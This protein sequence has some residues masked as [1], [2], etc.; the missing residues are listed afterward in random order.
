MT[1]DSPLEN[2]RQN[3]IKSTRKT[4]HIIDLEQTIFMLRRAMTFI[5]KLCKKRGYILFVPHH[6]KQEQHLYQ[7]SQKKVQIRQRVENQQEKSQEKNLEQKGAERFIA[8]RDKTEDFVALTAQDLENKEEFRGQA[9][10]EDS[11]GNVP[12]VPPTKDGDAAP[13]VGTRT[14]KSKDQRGFGTKKLPC[15]T[16]SESPL[17][18]FYQDFVNDDKPIYM[19]MYQRRKGRGLFE[20]SRTKYDS[21]SN[22]ETNAK[23]A[24]IAI[25]KYESLSHKL[26]KTLVQRPEGEKKTINGRSPS[27][28]TTKPSSTR[29]ISNAISLRKNNFQSRWPNT[30]NMPR[31]SPFRGVPAEMYQQ[32][33][34]LKK[35]LLV[36]LDSIFYRNASQ[37]N[38]RNT[39]APCQENAN[40]NANATSTFGLQTLNLKTSS[41]TSSSTSS[42]RLI[43][44]TNQ[45]LVPELLQET[46]LDSI[47]NKH[48]E[49]ETPQAQNLTKSSFPTIRRRKP[50]QEQ[51]HTASLFECGSP[52]D[53]ATAT[54]PILRQ[55]ESSQKREGDK[56]MNALPSAG[57]TTIR[58]LILEI[59]K[60]RSQRF[61]IPEALFLFDTIENH[62][63]IREAIKLQ[64][65]IIAIIDSN[66][67]TFGID[68]PIPGNTQSLDSLDLYTQFL[69]SAI[70]NAKKKEIQDIKHLSSN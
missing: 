2:G 59:R 26:P 35:N 34:T 29:R 9:K 22:S 27:T 44:G 47:S 43:N 1:S 53:T 28:G 45:K 66:S 7:Q 21:V 65:P 19:G 61:I 38:S 57:A 13:Q 24:S 31:F 18:F 14:C 42:S 63:L 25:T 8:T 54:V 56:D 55:K 69:F 30:R 20:R 16:L 70:S 52:T 32:A 10:N 11:H 64:I 12:I 49:K 37:R 60:Q 58:E 33:K 67:K 50:L 23:I 36:Q 62:T 17:N 51:L 39:F 48:V 41:G 3:G 68:Y 4:I 40:A 6:A 15:N 5:Q 46:P